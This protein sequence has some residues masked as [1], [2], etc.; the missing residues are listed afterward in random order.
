MAVQYNINDSWHGDIVNYNQDI[1]FEATPWFR[2]HVAIDW[3]TR[4]AKWQDLGL[5]T[6]TK[7]VFQEYLNQKE[8]GTL[9]TW[10]KDNPTY[11]EKW[12]DKVLAR[13]YVV[14]YSGYK[15]SDGQTVDHNLIDKVLADDDSLSDPVFFIEGDDDNGMTS[16]DNTTVTGF[17]I[18]PQQDGLVRIEGQWISYG[19]WKLWLV[20]G[21]FST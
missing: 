4:P 8:A 11:Q 18:I 2:Q 15:V 21:T 3:E 5:S 6:T 14:R 7:P 13:R 1:P 19:D 17:Q 9:N 12:L 10:L 16:T 20:D